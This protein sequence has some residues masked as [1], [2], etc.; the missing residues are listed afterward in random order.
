MQAAG[1]GTCQQRPQS[2]N[3]QN[4]KGMCIV[5]EVSSSV[6]RDLFVWLYY[7]DLRIIMENLGKG[8]TFCIKLLKDAS[9][10]NLIR[11]L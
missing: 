6:T 5:A 9:A 3:S 4:F 8:E 10:L 11:N 1:T 2:K 7:S